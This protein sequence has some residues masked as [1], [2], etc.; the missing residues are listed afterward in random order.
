MFLENGQFLKLYNSGSIHVHILY[1]C[2][3]DRPEII[4]GGGEGEEGDYC[5]GAYRFSQH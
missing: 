3:R 1:M 5:Q 2:V 4:I